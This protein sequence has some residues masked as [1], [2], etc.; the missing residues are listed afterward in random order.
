MLQVG[1]ALF[2]VP[3]APSP[4]CTIEELLFPVTLAPPPV[5]AHSKNPHCSA[6]GLGQVMNGLP[7]LLPCWTVRLL[8]NKT[9]EMN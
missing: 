9:L 4:T 3:G 2:F 5:S 7:R 6:L 1:G 8:K